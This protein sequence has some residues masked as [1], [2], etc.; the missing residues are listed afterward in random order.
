M[1]WD[2]GIERM[3]EVK[4]LTVRIGEKSILRDVNLQIAKGEAVVLFGPNGCGKTSLL[5]TIMGMHDFRV[6]SGQVFF[7]GTDITGLTIDER[8]PWT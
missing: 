1:A 6:E 2:T 3:I 7:N 8:A 4:E 5:K